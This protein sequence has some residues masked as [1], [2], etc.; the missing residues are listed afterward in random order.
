MDTSS[1]LR[2]SPNE[3]FGHRSVPAAQPVTLDYVGSVSPAPSHD[4]SC[5][6]AWNPSDDFAGVPT[7]RAFIEGCCRPLVPN[8]NPSSCPSRGG[9]HAVGRNVC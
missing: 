9:A 7:L 4:E 1:C 8:G 5:G 2:S 3:E 6:D